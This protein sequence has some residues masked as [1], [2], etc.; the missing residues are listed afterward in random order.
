MSDVIGTGLKLSDSQGN[1]VI[2]A[3][4][5]QNILFFKKGNENKILLYGNN[6]QIIVR[7][8]V[9]IDAKGSSFILR[10]DQGKNIRFL[11]EK[12]ENLPG[13]F[14]VNPDT[15]QMNASDASIIAGGSEHEGQLI[16]NDKNYKLIFKID[17]QTAQL[18]I[19]DKS[20]NLAIRL[21]AEESFLGAGGPKREG[22]LV[23]NDKNYNPIF[24]LDGQTAQLLINDTSNNLTIRMDAQEAFLGAGGPNREGQL[25][26]NDKNF[27]PRIKLDASDATVITGGNG[28]S[29]KLIVRDENYNDQVIIDGSS[30]D[31]ILT[32]AD[33]AED[34]ECNGIEKIEPGSVVTLDDSGQIQ[35]SHLPY[36][37]K[38]VG[39]VSGAAN[40]KPGIILGRQ[41]F[42]KNKLP[43]AL[44]GRV[45]CKVDAKN[46]PI[47]V[48][49][50]LTTSSTLGH[51]MKATDQRKAFG[52]VIGK[53]MASL[54]NKTGLIPIIVSLQ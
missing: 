11:T 14:P 10:G 3:D 20:N 53:S 29:G 8:S 21:D 32:N 25:V 48:G 6:G 22:Q 19:N 2:T 34:F 33:C 13:S 18:L 51:A 27:Q 50:L 9:I 39:V 12:S 40:F 17:A 45:Y 30:G 31:I 38:V 7:G 28:A 15:I 1:E 16:L 52:S 41:I 47:R 43:I 37:K 35:Q 4:T 44:M 46:E 24:K 36:D 42:Q 54:S 5:N 49:D 23:L 26:L